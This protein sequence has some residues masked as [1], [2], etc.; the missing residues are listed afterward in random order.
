MICEPG[1]GITVFAY[2]GA[3]TLFQ[4]LM[5]DM[6]GS[7][8]VLG[9]RAGTK[10]GLFSLSAT[11]GTLAVFAFRLFDVANLCPEGTIQ[12]VD[13]CRPL[14]FIV[15]C[16]LCSLAFFLSCLLARRRSAV[17][18]RALH[19]RLIDDPIFDQ[20][21][22]DT[23]EDIFKP[24]SQFDDLEPQDYLSDAPKVASLRTLNGLV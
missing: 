3:F 12:N 8:A 15:A 4:V 2:S 23:M 17:E 1:V 6:F 22:L 24:S 19:E 18:P 16:C 9:R 21:S 13:P 20:M 7:G 10:Y 11:L 5:F 14:S